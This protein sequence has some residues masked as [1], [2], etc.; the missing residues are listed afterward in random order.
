MPVLL[1]MVSVTLTAF[2]IVREKERGTLE[3]LLV[4]PVRPLG[5]MMGKLMPYFALS[6]F[7]T[8]VILLFMRYAFRVPIHGSVLLLILLS[9][10]YLFVNLATGMLI[11]TKASSQSEAMQLATMT[12]LPSIFLSGYIFPVD[13]MPQIF[14]MLSKFIPATYMMEISRGVILRS[15]GLPELWLNALKLF[16]SGVVVLL[17]AANRFR[18]MIV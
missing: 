13:N 1:L 7:E 16:A 8:A 18:K 10:C 3:Q 12:L 14:Q 11:S 2:S 4:T 6:L 17:I 5:L 9:T 15:A